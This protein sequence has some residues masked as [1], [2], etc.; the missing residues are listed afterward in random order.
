MTQ[1]SLPKSSRTGPS[2]YL[3]TVKGKL[4]ENWADSFNGVL[5]DFIEDDGTGS[6]TVLSCQVR[7]QAELTGLL[8]WIHD[9]NLV[10]LEV[11]SVK[12]EVK[13]ARE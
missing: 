8:N 7:D 3:I 5:I 6:R 1:K 9:L 12:E 4:E 10:L 11:T 13:D 2:K